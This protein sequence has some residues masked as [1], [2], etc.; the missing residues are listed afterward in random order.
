MWVKSHDS[1]TRMCYAKIFLQCLDENINF[2]VD[3]FFSN[4]VV[5][6]FQC[7]VIG[8]AAYSQF[9]RYHQHQRDV[10][11]VESADVFFLT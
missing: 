9:V 2:I 7:Y 3:K 10:F 1:N 5:N 8:D 4:D 11:F 6:F